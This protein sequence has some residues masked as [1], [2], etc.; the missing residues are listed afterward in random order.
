MTEPTKRS[1]G[2]PLYTVSRLA[3]ILGFSEPRLRELARTVG[4]YYRQFDRRVKEKTRTLIEATGPLKI[5][6]RRILDRLL[7]NLEPFERSFGAIK[8]RSTKQNAALHLRGRFIA[9]L[10]IKDFYPSVRHTRVYEFFVGSG[11]TA[12]VA[13]LLTLLTTRDHSLPLGASTSPFIADQVLHGVD[14]RIDALARKGGLRYSRYVDDITLSGSF[15]LTRFRKTVVKILRQSGFKAKASK[16]MLYGPG[17][18]RERIITGVRIDGGKLSAPLD[19][20]AELE[21]HLRSAIAQSRHQRPEGD[22]YP[23]EH[24]FGK[25]GYLRWLDPVLGD[26]LMRLYRKVKWRHL[27]WAVRVR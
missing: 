7:V 8:G 1:T 25:I 4:G 6:Q 14:V 20:V 23:R 2:I 21:T 24:Y 5:L 17:D 27:E 12:D 26:Q 9:K 19:F 11:C 13:R 18:Q 10:D 22:F 3:L 15:P 16:L